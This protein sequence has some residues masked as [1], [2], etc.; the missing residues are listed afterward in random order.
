MEPGLRTSSGSSVQAVIDALA[1]N[2]VVLGANGMIDAVN[3]SWVRF[4]A[5]NGDPGGRSTGPGQGYLSA[6]DAGA[7]LDG[8]TARA[9]ADGIRSV[10]AGQAADFAL[11][12]PCHSPQVERWFVMLVAPFGHG[13]AVVA[14]VDVTADHRPLH[15]PMSPTPSGALVT[16][17]VEL[18]IAAAQPNSDE[19]AV[20]YVDIDDFKEIN[21]TVGR[22]SG[23]AL[24]VEFVQRLRAVA[25]AGAT[26]RRFASDEFVVIVPGASR[27]AAG[28]LAARIGEVMRPPF[29][30]GA[31]TAMI[32]V[33]TGVAHYPDDAGAARDLLRQADDAMAESKRQGRDTWQFHDD[34]VAQRRSRRLALARGLRRSMA[35]QQLRMVYQPQVRLS[36]GQVVG[37]EALM[38]WDCPELGD[39]SPSEFV[40]VAESTGRILPMGWWALRT[41]VAQ[42]AEWRSVGIDPGVLAVNVSGRHFSQPE[43]AE[44]VLALLDSF[45]HA[46]QGLELEVTEHSAMRQREASI[47]AMGHLS[48][49]GVRI[50]LDDFGT[51]YSSLANL[52]AFP[53]HTAK[54]DSSFV[55]RVDTDLEA[56][57]LVAA[58]VELIR[59][60][61]LRCVAEGVQTPAQADFLRQRGCDDVQGFGY[62]PPLTP[63]EFVRWLHERN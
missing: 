39:P 35:E 24:L 1:A 36:D 26:V 8:S 56:R 50:A 14:H 51:G 53:L 13:G 38:R 15:D 6:I 43:F 60:L 33:S 3:T 12:Y 49:A 29:D 59:S 16:G 54:I 23:D 18:A 2:V 4:A 47:R 21:D 34:T 63:Q 20:L 7:P 58:M 5:E 37:L 48:E 22:E 40:P 11:E 41:A 31:D 17:Q 57:R 44:R 9:A 42:L 19:L 28:H 62:A 45:D 55:G 30:L 25:P 61:G 46:G 52:S 10:L 27:E 32:T